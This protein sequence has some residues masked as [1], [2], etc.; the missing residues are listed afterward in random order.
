MPAPAV[1]G[2]RRAGLRAAGWSRCGAALVAGIGSI[3]TPGALPAI[4]ALAAIVAWHLAA[5]AGAQAAGPARSAA[6]VAADLPGVPAMATRP[7]DLRGLPVPAG[8]PAAGGSAANEAA[9]AA[10][11]AVTVAAATAEAPA[12]VSSRGVRV[13]LEEGMAA[14]LSGDGQISIEAVPR[15]GEALSSFA[16]RLCGD[17]RLAPQVLEANGQGAQRAARTAETPA[18]A[19]TQATLRTARAHLAASTR[20][21][22]GRTYRLPFEILSPAWQLKAAQA[23][24]PADHGDATGWRHQARG[25]GPLR[26]EN[27]WQLSEWFT[28]KGENFR[29]I[30]EYNN[31]RDEDVA[32]GAV[33]TIPSELLLP[34]F[35]AALPV[36]EK[37]FVLSYGKDDQGEYAIYRLRPGEALY[38][39]VVV[40]FTGRIYAADVNAL[41]ADI[42]HRSGIDDVTAIPVGFKVKIPLDLLQ[43]EFLPEGDARRKEYE[44]GLRASSH[45]SNQVRARGLEGITVILDAGHGGH[46]SGATMS[47]V[48]ESLYVY[49]IAVRLKGLLE[50]NT[51]AAVRLTTR[52]GEDFRVVDSDVLPESRRHA[53]LTNPPYPIDDPAVGVNLRWYLANSYFRR[54]VSGDNDPQKVVFLSIHADSLHPSLRGAMA[55]VPAARMRDESYGKSGAI[56][57]AR[58]EFRES[59]RVEFPWNQRVQSEGLSRE[60]AKQ[61]IGAFEERG[62]P[63][64]PFTP[65]RDHIIRNRSEWVPA[66]LR[67]NSVPAKM[68]LEVCN[69]NN[70]LDRRLLQTRSYRQNVAAAMLGGLLAYYGQGAAP[71]AVRVARTG[72]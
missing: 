25:L 63:V 13:K 64:H 68:L 1:P 2:S 30:R 15:R 69:L 18:A 49:D 58:E 14:R 41:A 61:I 33:L 46:D 56:Y 32:R 54:A 67:Y 50:A 23:L 39:G 40:R 9:G 19:G 34:A 55:Y 5:P 51:A 45:F 16:Q 53:V 48:W 62:L 29:A 36:P 4:T 3:G 20:L 72:R 28:G 7:A 11:S 65:V 43:P 8:A 47:G 27:L 17:A 37:P 38:S 44:A 31:L 57:E 24:F 70:D 42:A 66:V 59:P 12:A 6:D 26:R 22:A 52:D 60:L 21:L 71:P 10:A 35:G